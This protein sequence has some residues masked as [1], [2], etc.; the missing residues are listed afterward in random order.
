[1][2]FPWFIN[3]L[4]GELNLPVVDK[5]GITGVYDITLSYTP[6]RFSTRRIMPATASRYSPPFNSNSV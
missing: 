5:T 4:G 6:Q 2:D 1:M 3:L